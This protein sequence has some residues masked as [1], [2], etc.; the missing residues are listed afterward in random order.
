MSYPIEL[1]TSLECGLSDFIT[2]GLSKKIK[3]NGSR[4][5]KYVDCLR[6]YRDALKESSVEDL[7]KS[8][9]AAYLDQIPYEMAELVY[10]YKTLHE[11]NDPRLVSRF[12]SIVQGPELIGDDQSGSSRDFQFELHIAALLFQA[13][14]NSLDSILGM[15]SFAR[16][17]TVLSS[18]NANGHANMKRLRL[19][20]PPPPIKSR[21]PRW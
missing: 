1:I 21:A 5:L 16:C 9:S 20:M 4:V 8:Q 19:P 6:S 13:K 12:Q 18:S 14:I 15:I 7:V 10:L 3:F 17:T 2:W 11:F